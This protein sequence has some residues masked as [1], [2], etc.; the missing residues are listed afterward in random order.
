[1]R[2]GK[3]A[4]KVALAGGLVGSA[5]SEDFQEGGMGNCTGY[6]QAWDECPG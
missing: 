2:A 5:L 3:K 6:G 1:M 4:G